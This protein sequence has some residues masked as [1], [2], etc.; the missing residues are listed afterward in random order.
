MR[1]DEKWWEVRNGK[2]CGGIVKS[3]DYCCMGHF[4]HSFYPDQSMLTFRVTWLCIT[5]IICIIFIICKICIICLLCIICILCMIC[6][7]CIICIIC[8]IFCIQ[9]TWIVVLRTLISCNNI[10]SLKFKSFLRGVKWRV[11]VEPQPISVFFYVWLRKWWIR[12]KLYS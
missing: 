9:T 4:I 10:F 2:Q 6:K 7:K 11:F 12:R 8:I 5:C 3:K 1:S